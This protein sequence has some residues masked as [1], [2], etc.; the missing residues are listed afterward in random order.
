M[1]HRC[2]SSLLRLRLLIMGVTSEALLGGDFEL[3][4]FTDLER[5]TPRREILS[6]LI[7]TFSTSFLKATLDEPPLR[8]D[9]L[10]ALL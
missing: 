10:G 9:S 5:L 6:G 8:P 7:Y 3:D 4:H 1:D 2:K